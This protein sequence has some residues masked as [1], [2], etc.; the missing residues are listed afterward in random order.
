MP[1]LLEVKNLNKRFGGIV[2]VKNV[3]FQIDKG[4]IL[5]LIG[6][7]GAGKT[8]LFNLITGFEKSDSGTVTF[9]G[10]DITKL[11]PH[12][13]VNMGMARTFQLVKP[14]KRMLTLENVAA[15][16]YSKR[17]MKKRKG[18]EDIPSKAIEA[19]LRVELIPPPANILKLAG[20]L[21][22]GDLKRLEIARALVAEPELLL[23]DEP[24]GGLSLEETTGLT[25]LIQKLHGEEGLT[26]VIVEH[27][28]RELMRLVKRVIVMD[29]GEKIAEGKPKEIANN[30][31]VIEAYLG[32]GG[33]IV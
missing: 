31:R 3:S 28:M 11:K 14:F 23:L 25:S 9:K 29:F 6:P 12:K 2:A 24:F 1:P 15:A 5:G 20:D 13:I 10:K 4:Q 22:H 19:L 33:G 16:Y 8:T 17:A 32:K 27:K 30:P 21:S 26:I 18:K 7:N